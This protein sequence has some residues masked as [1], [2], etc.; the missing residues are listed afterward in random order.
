MRSSPLQTLE[1]IANKKIRRIIGLMSG[2]SLDGIDIALVD[3]EN[4]PALQIQMKQFIT[5]PYSESLRTLIQ[6]QTR[7]DSSR[8]DKICQLHIELGHFYGKQILN[9]LED[10]KVSTTTVDCIASHGQTLFHSPKSRNHL[11][12]MMNATLQ[13][14]DG[15]QIACTTGIVTI[16]DF[17]TKDVAVGGEGAPLLPY[18]DRLLFQSDQSRIIHNLGGMSNVTYLP[19]SSVQEDII[20]FDIGPANILINLAM[21]KLFQFPYDQYGQTAA[22]GRTSTVLLTKLMQ[23]PFFHLPPPKSTG[24]ELFGEQF[25]DDVCIQ[26]KTMSLRPQDIVATLTELTAVSSR[27]A[28]ENFLPEI[29]QEVFFTGGGIHN[30]TLMK[31]IQTLLPQVK[32]QTLEALGIS[33]DAREAISFALFANEFL[34][35]KTVTFTGITGAQKEVSLGKISFPH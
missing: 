26:A 30:H 28:Y 19:S 35:G 27:H 7:I 25:V 4:D 1:L 9:A 3:I 31:H 11:N 17:R 33:S 6:S 10:W 12:E 8:V 24:R 15:D 14:G 2:T 16:S 22:Q 18:V 34:S 29:P 21:Q 5:I 32:I 13:I 23:T 20:A